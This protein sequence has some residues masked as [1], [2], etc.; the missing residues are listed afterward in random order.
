MSRNLVTK[1]NRQL[2]DNGP[3]QLSDHVVQKI[4]KLER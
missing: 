2:C 3:L 4:A 1:L